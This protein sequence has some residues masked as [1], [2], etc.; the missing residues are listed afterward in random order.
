MIK[1]RTARR[2]T[3]IAL[4]LFIGATAY[5]L[6]DHPPRH[7][8]VVWEQVERQLD[9]QIATGYDEGWFSK[10]DIMEGNGVKASYSPTTA[11]KNFDTGLSE[12][13][14]QVDQRFFYGNGIED[15]TLSLMLPK[16]PSAIYADNRELAIFGREKTGGVE[17]NI[18]LQEIIPPEIFAKGS[19]PLELTIYYK[20]SNSEKV[21]SDSNRHFEDAERYFITFVPKQV[22]K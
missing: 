2:L 3:A 11:V 1:Y 6:G 17:I 16:A 12:R 19:F 22:G 8:N 7:E 18:P 14:R 13:S 9:G 21:D 4:P 20:S 5:V 15:L 10:L